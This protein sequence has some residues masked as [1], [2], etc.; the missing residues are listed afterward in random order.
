MSDF[1]TPTSPRSSF[2]AVLKRFSPLL[3]PNLGTV[4]LVALVL[5]VY[6]AW[7]APDSPAAASLTPSVISYQGSLTNAASQPVN[8]NVNM[9]F[10]LYSVPTGGTALWTE[11]RSGVNA[12]P[13]NNGYFSLLLG[14]LTPIPAG[15]WN[16]AQLYLGIQV[17]SDAEMSPRQ[18]VGA[19]PVAMQAAT[20][21]TVPDA[22]LSSRHFAPLI[23]KD[24][25]PGVLSTTSTSPVASGVVV[26]PTCENNCT[27]LVLHRTLLAH[28]AANGGVLVQVLVDGVVSFTHT[29]APH[30]AYS[31]SD[32]TRWV[33]VAGFKFIDLTAGIHTVEVKFSCIT[34][35]TC[36]YYGANDSNEMEALSVIVFGRP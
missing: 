25:N 27:L 10:R 16:N 22:A 35:G 20:A 29:A 34:P 7:A 6:R 3:L 4:L 32:L 23:Y 8:G 11:T 2:V 17:G 1:S 9:T 21:L 19:V 13:V 36:Y 5:V 15:V 12:V 30:L 14:G 26:Y 31:P 18:P 33:E 24:T 28:S